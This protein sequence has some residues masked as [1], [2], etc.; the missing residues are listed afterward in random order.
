MAEAGAISPGKLSRYLAHTCCH[1]LS[2]Y[3]CISSNDNRPGVK[4]MPRARRFGASQH[5]VGAPGAWVSR[6]SGR[7]QDVRSERAAFGF[8]AETALSP[9]PPQQPRHSGPDHEF[10]AAA[11]RHRPVHGPDRPP[12]IPPGTPAAP[13]RPALPSLRRSPSPHSHPSCPA[14]CAH[15]D[16]TCTRSRAPARTQRTCTCLG[17]HRARKHTARAHRGAHAGCVQRPSAAP[18][19]G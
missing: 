2:I 7:R 3:L 19:A 5:L 4:V 1:E 6:R 13:G 9:D 12:D 15:T 11:T 8:V 10:G 18:P 16:R 17:A 14:A